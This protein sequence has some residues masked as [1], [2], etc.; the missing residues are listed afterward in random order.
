MS[1]KEGNF[2]CNQVF[3]KLCLRMIGTVKDE[4]DLFAV[5]YVGALRKQ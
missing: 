1:L 4:D 2:I 3:E 5:L